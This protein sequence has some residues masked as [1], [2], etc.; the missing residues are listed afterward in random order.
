MAFLSIGFRPFFLAAALFAAVA[1]I[2]WAI[3]LA[4][5][6]VP[7]PG[8][9][10][11]W[12]GREMAFG[13]A[14]ALVA[15]FLLTAVGNWTG[16][17]VAG[18]GLI[19]ALVLL[20]LAGRLVHAAGFVPPVLAAAVDLA[21]LPAL[22]VV[23]AIPLIRAGVARNL[24]VPP[25][26]LAW[27]AF[28]AAVHGEALGLWSGV[29]RPAVETVVW[30]LGV[31]M[32]LIGGRVIPFFTSRRLPHATVVARPRAGLAAAIVAVLVPAAL[33]VS[34]PAA[35]AAMAVVGV[36][37]LFRLSGWGTKET[38]GEPMLWVLHAGYAILGLAYLL[39]AVH[40]LGGPVPPNAPLHAIAAGALGTLG[41]G[42]MSRVALGHTG[43]PIVADRWVVT[44]FVLVIVGGL[45][46]VAAAFWP[47]PDLWVVAGVLWG[48]AFAVYA[49]RYFGVVT[50]P[51]PDA[52]PLG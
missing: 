29:A 26:I 9:P 15:G 42:M 33:L 21:F 6:P 25:L 35:A 41:L 27:A 50:R 31:L 8:D 18:P 37:V 39:G 52:V 22:A 11:L 2:Y 30:L 43:R 46:R 19:A 24:F 32:V 38:L 28:N 34:E 1:T 3:Y 7:V 5:A 44:G 16:R 4:G 20:W 13:F 23:L 12:H 51:R 48:G 36:L 10:F 47:S 45:T 40:Y 49:V 14:S 17:R